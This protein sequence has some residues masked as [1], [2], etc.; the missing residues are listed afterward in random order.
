MMERSNPKADAHGT[1][2]LVEGAQLMARQRQDGAVFDQAVAPFL[3]QL[4]Q[5]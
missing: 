2:A 1:M 4:T 5:M 3:A